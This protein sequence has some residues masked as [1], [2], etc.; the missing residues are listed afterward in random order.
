MGRRR[1]EDENV[2][3]PEPEDLDEGGENE[4]FHRVEEHF[5]IPSLFANASSL[6]MNVTPKNGTPTPPP[7]FLAGDLDEVNAGPAPGTSP[8]FGGSPQTY[9]IRVQRRGSDGV[10]LDLGHMAPTAGQE[11]LISEYKKPGTY[12]LTLVDD[13]GEPQAK[14]R[15]INIPP[16]H[17]GFAKLQAEASS[18][19]LP[20]IPVS[21]GLP[22]EVMEMIKKQIEAMERRAENAERMLQEE[23]AQIVRDREALIQERLAVTNQSMNSVVEIQEKVF[24]RGQRREDANSLQLVAMFQSNAARDQAQWAH[25]LALMERKAEIENEKLKIDRDREVARFA[26]ER[27]R[28]QQ[29]WDR[30]KEEIR[31]REDRIRQDAEE[32][33]ELQREFFRQMT[34]VQSKQADPLSQ[35]SQTFEKMAPMMDFFRGGDKK[36]GEEAPA[37]PKGLIEVI[38]AVA[39]MW[40]ASQTNLQQTAIQTQAQL[41]AARLP[42]IPQD[43]EEEYEDEEEIEDS[44]VAVEE[45]PPVVL[46]PAQVASER[47]KDLEPKVCKAARKTLRTL[48]ADLTAT[49]DTQ[50]DWFAKITMALTTEPAVGPYLTAVGIRTAALEAGGEP[51]LVDLFIATLD[52]TGLV[53]FSVPRT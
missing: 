1:R 33:N 21:S 2:L 43:D 24:E 50:S 15:V 8:F 13:F 27:E 34:S 37:Q 19:A 49:K 38:G 23:R 45:V 25:Q 31:M 18:A 36:E 48:V 52:N 14:S 11:Q 47:A 6:G 9:R 28:E 39:Q 41:Q 12:T 20:P 3:P 46:T 35:F 17:P 44:G 7:R 30:E 32:K 4:A 42:Q 26:A 10:Q 5:K 51:S 16:D 53:P 29:R 40:I 22:P